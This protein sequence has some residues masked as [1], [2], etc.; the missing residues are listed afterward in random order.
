M[1]RDLG[2]RGR[3]SSTRSSG[4]PRKGWSN[5][6]PAR[7]HV[8]VALRADRPKTAGSC[9]DHQRHPQPRLS[10]AIDDAAIRFGDRERLPFAPRAFTTALPAFDAFPWRNGRAFLRSTGAA[11]ATTSW[12]TVIRQATGRLRQVIA[13]HLRA[14]RGITCDAEQIFIVGGAQQAFHLIGSTLVDP[15]RQGLVR[16]PWC[17]R[18]PQQPDRQPAPTSCRSRSIRT[19]AGLIVDGIM[20]ARRTSALHWHAVPPATA[21]QRD[22][23]RAS[24]QLLRAAERAGAWIIEDD[25]DGEFF[26]GG[27]PPPTLK[28]VDTAGPCHLRR[29]VLASR[30]FPRSGWDLSSSHRRRSSTRS[31]RYEQGPARRAVIAQ[32]VGRA[33]SSTEGLFTSHLTAPD[34]THLR[35]AAR[36]AAPRGAPAPLA[37]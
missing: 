4:S 10:K 7:D 12:A 15:G 27:G 22:E 36:R 1:A 28:S 37:G 5:R 34:A 11:A 30:C 17:H 19:G 9:A 33:S 6:G 23:P 18:R 14:N 29:H 26:F 31:A 8:S 25:Y 2:S 13:S 20:A 24:L 35:R 32:A 21:R 3:R 16:E